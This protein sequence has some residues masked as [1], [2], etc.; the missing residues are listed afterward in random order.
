MAIH[1]LDVPAENEDL[2]ELSSSTAGA[3]LCSEESGS[4]EPHCGEGDCDPYAEMLEADGK[5]CPA[6]SE[7][8]TL[9]ADYDPY[10][11][12]LEE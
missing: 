11:E 3:N 9:S 12:P 8:D 2:P 6:S 5:S 10:A 7:I 4:D 1:I